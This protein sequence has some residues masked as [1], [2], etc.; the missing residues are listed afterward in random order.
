MSRV[1]ANHEAVHVSSRSVRRNCYTYVE[2]V[3]L[4]QRHFLVLALLG[5][6][7]ATSI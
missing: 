6:P 7:L 4:A 5:G 2:I 1:S 3:F